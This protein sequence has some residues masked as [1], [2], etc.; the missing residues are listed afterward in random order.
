M[1]K[2]KTVG[3]RSAPS[4]RTSHY[5]KSPKPK[6]VTSEKAAVTAKYVVRKQTRKA[7]KTG[8]VTA[9]KKGLGITKDEGGKTLSNAVST[10]GYKKARG[11]VNRVASNRAKAQPRRGKKA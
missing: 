10:L 11:L 6:N 4:S 3:G 5:V 2:G 9:T 8:P 1:P 7:L